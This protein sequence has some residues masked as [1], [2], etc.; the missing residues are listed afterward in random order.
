MGGITWSSFEKCILYHSVIWSVDKNG[1][2]KYT[3]INENGE[4][5]ILDD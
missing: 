1:I 5:I 3:F 2:P 4:K